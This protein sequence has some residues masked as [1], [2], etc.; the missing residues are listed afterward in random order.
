MLQATDECYIYI[1]D[2]KE[3][4]TGSLDLAHKRA[5]EGTEI[6]VIKIDLL[7]NMLVIFPIRTKYCHHLDICCRGDKRNHSQLT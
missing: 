4:F 6:K 7:L 5:D 1:K 3:L 2:G